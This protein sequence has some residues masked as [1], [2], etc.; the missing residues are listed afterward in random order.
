MRDRTFFRRVMMLLAR[1]IESR[2]MALFALPAA[3]SGVR[4]SFG[5]SFEPRMPA[6]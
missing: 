4:L 2:L 5:F 6:S 3:G 1:S